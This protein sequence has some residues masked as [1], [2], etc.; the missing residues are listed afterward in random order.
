MDYSIRFIGHVIETRKPTKDWPD[1]I[2]YQVV[3]RADEEKAVRDFLTLKGN[4]IKLYQ[5]IFTQIDLPGQEKS[6]MEFGNG[7]FVPMHMFT[8]VSFSV[9]RLAG[10]MPDENDKGA[11]VQ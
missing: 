2:E 3:F 6:D 9:R 8:H 4:E 7:K 1:M 5:G 10:E 11:F